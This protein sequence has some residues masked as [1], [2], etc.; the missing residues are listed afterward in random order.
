MTTLSLIITIIIQYG[1]NLYLAYLFFSNST[2]KN[3]IPKI[4]LCIYMVEYVLIYGLNIDKLLPQTITESLNFIYLMFFL[5]CL[6]SMPFLYIS[7]WAI[8]KYWIGNK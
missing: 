8:D 6:F 1:L 3:I 7:A 5:G 2:Y 4:F